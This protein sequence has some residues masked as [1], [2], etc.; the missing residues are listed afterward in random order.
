M[1]AEPQGW[2]TVDRRL[3]PLLDFADSTFAQAT[4]LSFSIAQSLR[5]TKGVMS[6]RLL[7]IW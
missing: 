3:L 7:E 5:L 4:Q 1:L 6:T 2:L